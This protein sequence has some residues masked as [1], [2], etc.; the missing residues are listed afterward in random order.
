M[1]Q[2]W[3]NQLYFGDNLAILREHV[4][5]ESVDL[6]YLDP[7]FNSK[8]DYNV[9]FKTTA[10]EASAAQAMALKDTWTWDE[11]AARAY[12]EVMTDVRV[13]ANLRNL[14]EALKKFLTVDTGTR[15][16]SMMAYL[17][18]MALRLVELHRVL[19]PTGSFDL[20]SDRSF[21]RDE[22]SHLF[23]MERR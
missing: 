18:M 15:G 21:Q 13:P 4:A 3:R 10:G 9:L 16:N 17:T 1:A 11:E 2:D 5:D 20:H 6:V 23:I 8:A 12:H 19:K 14:M 22:R 7:P